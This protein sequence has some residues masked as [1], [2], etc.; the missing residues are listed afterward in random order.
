[1]QDQLNVYGKQRAR[2]AWLLKGDRNTKFFHAY[3]S[4]RRRKNTIKQLKEDGGIVVEGERLKLFVANHYQNLFMSHAGNQCHE[5]LRC[6]RTRVS[7]EMNES[8]LT[9]FTSEEVF[10]ALESI[11]DLKAPGTDE[12]SS[13]FYKKF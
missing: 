10:V 4:K 2:I 6:V 13:I 8:L 1:L 3:A 7:L 5:V 9:P 11:G 12:M